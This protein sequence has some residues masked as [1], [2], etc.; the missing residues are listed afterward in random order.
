MGHTHVPGSISYFIFFFSSRRVDNPQDKLVH[1]QRDDR[2]GNGTHHMRHQA[3]IETRHSLLLSDE[4]ETLE[5][6]S[7]F[8]DA[9]L[10]WRLAQTG[11][12][13][14]AGGVRM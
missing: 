2:G 10:K 14:L 1:S 13:Y 5:Q 12:N 3:S 6:T 4:S 11:P 9:I 8:G 7:V